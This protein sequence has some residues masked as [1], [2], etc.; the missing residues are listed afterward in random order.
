MCGARGDVRFGPEADIAVFID[1]VG[2]NQAASP[3]M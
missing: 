1:L 2:G 3:E